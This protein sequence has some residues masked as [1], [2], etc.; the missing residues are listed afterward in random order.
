MCDVDGFKRLNDECGHPYGDLVLERLSKIL[1][2]GRAS[3]IA[4][5]YGGEEFGIILPNTTVD[6]AM[7]VAERHRAA[8]E[9]ETWPGAPGRVITASFGI[10]DLASLGGEHGPDELVAVADAALYRAK[11]NGRNRIE[12]APSHRPA[13]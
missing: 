2:S 11:V 13:H 1:Q 7:E 10:A 5:R 12:V 6:E 3:D 4:C 9:Q 8:F